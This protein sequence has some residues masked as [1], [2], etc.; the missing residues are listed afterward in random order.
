MTNHQKLKEEILLLS[1]AKD[2]HIAVGEWELYHTYI[3]ENMAHCLCGHPIQEI[4]VLSNTKNGAR[5]EV[6]NHCVNKFI[7]LPSAPIFSALKKIKK[8]AE[9]SLNEKFLNFC[10]EKCWLND[11]EL[12]FYYKIW[13]KKNLSFKQKEYKKLINEKI[14][15][16]IFRAS[17]QQPNSPRPTATRASFCQA[18]PAL[19]VLSNPTASRSGWGRKIGSR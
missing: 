18:K 2:W 9:A 4:C 13:R 12:S 19:V 15:R 10:E 1:V 7:G 5:A 17:K 8:D 14:L 11:R 3:D 16:K 6:G